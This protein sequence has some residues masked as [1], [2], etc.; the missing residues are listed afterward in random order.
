MALAARLPKRSKS[1]LYVPDIEPGRAIKTIARFSDCITLTVEES[2][3]FFS[4][5]TSPVVTGYPLRPGLD[6]WTHSEAI[7]FFALQET[8]PILLVFGG[9][10]GAHSINQAVVAAYRITKFS[11]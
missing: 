6:S 9:S 1:L 8:M 4:A 2:Q 11:T 7:N 3:A 10:R 5:H